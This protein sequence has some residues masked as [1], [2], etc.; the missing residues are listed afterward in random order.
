MDPAAAYAC[1]PLGGQAAK[2]NP[3]TVKLD[4]LARLASHLD[5]A[6]PGGRARCGAG[7]P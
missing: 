1:K 4:S 3:L 6:T 7:V 5:R 2:V